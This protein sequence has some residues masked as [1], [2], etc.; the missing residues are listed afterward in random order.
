MNKDLKRKSIIRCNMGF[1]LFIVCAMLLAI[2]YFL[3]H[4]GE[5]IRSD[6]K[7]Y[8]EYFL[9]IFLDK[10]LAGTGMIVYPIG[11]ALLESPFLLAALFLSYVNG[12]DIDNGMALC[13]HGAVSFAAFFYWALGMLFIYR[14][15]RRKYTSDISVLSC[16]CLTLG[17]MLPAYVID[18]SSYSHAYGFFACSA[19]FCYVDY[20]ERNRNDKSA[21][22][23]DLILGLILGLAFRI[24]NTNI[25]IGAAYLFYMVTDTK[26]FI[27]RL[28]TVISIRLIPQIIAF[29]IPA[30]AQF[31][32]WRIMNGSW[33]L[34]SYGN[35]G[36]TYILKPQILR[37]LFSDAK[38]LFI[39]CPILIVAV[40]SM[41]AFRRDN[42]EYRVS[43]WVIFAVVTALA[44]TWWCWWLGTAY[45]Q[46]MH[47][48]ILCVFAIPMAS[49]FDNSIHILKE[50]KNNKN[51]IAL[52]CMVIFTN[53]I[54]CIFIIL[55][56]IWFCG[57]LEWKI[58]PN[59][60]TWYQL[61]SYLQET[62]S[63]IGIR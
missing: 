52:K 61:K 28:N 2:V 35:Q 23:L 45:G 19:F 20:Y 18:L 62:L 55:N 41:I 16:I 43:Q 14:L 38:G 51:V 57:S 48:D 11:T 22:V 44:A 6:G 30:V 63:K 31:V 15:L 39:F 59:F 27:K 25:I 53:T 1:V 32:I 47:C 46:R 29:A 12:W 60:A 13:F 54:C 21:V 5:N 4:G 26:S 17:T 36:F 34:Y 50:K 42:P 9:R 10:E 24:R 40:I 3:N 7:F 56:I 58:N 33:V 49:F 37:V 8:Y